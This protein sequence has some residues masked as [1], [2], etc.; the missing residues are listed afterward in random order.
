MFS[1]AKRRLRNI[2]E[3]VTKAY[4]TNQILE[5]KGVTKLTNESAVTSDA[6]RQKELLMGN[7]KIQMN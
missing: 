1:F 3:A 4:V 2:E 5:Q 7:Y 6:I